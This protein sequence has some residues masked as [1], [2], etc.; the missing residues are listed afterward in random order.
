MP[1]DPSAYPTL[2]AR[3]VLL[4]AT[5]DI[6]FGAVRTYG[7]VARAVGSPAAA[8]AVGGALAGNPVPIVVPCHR[9]IAAGGSLSGYS[10]GAK[11]AGLR[12]KRELLRLEG[13]LPGA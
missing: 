3:R 7:E 8:R 9:V 10:G 1:V 4:G 6:P 2:F 11:G 12:W 5:S 13:A